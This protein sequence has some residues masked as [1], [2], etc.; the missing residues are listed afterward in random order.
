MSSGPATLL[1][2]RD[3]PLQASFLELFFDLSFVFALRQL[4]VV[5]LDDVSLAGAARTG[6]LLLPLWSVWVV[7]AWFTDWFDRDNRWIQALLVGATLGVLLMSVAVPEATGDRALLFAGAYVVLHVGRSLVTA[8][9]LRGHPLRRRTLRILVW[10]VAS[11]VLWL[12]GAVWPPGRVPLWVLAA[13]WDLAGPHLG[14]PVPGLGR[15][16][17]GELRL[18]G[19]HLTDRFQQ[20]FIVAL[21]ELVIAAGLAY[22][23]TGLAPPESIA[24]LLAFA[25]AVLI[26]RL[27]VRPAGPRLG[28]AIDERNPARFATLTGNL[29]GIMIAGVLGTSVAA[30]LVIT[31][32]V[33]VESTAATVLTAVGPALFLTG[34]IALSAVVYRRWSW[35]RLLGLPALLAIALAGRFAPLLVVTAA[36]VGVLLAVAL[37]E[38][39]PAVPARRSGVRA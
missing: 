17:P 39:R 11:G 3:E 29:H 37:A 19:R 8:V 5:L 27:Y 1:R 28:A 31:H 33:E 4:S 36:T 6:L 9:S 16:Q 20:V 24:F 15:A 30:D 35:S 32:P 25:A 12:T 10:F 13:G 26:G 38:R 14:W 34:R 2:R 21:G 22:A 7:T 18:R 23:S